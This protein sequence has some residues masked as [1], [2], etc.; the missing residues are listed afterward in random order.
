MTFIASDS[1][2][3]IIPNDVKF[4]VNNDISGRMNIINISNYNKQL[5]NNNKQ[6]NNN[7]KQFS[8]NLKEILLS[9]IKNEK[10]DIE[11]I[12]NK[13]NSKGTDLEKKS[14]YYKLITN[15]NYNNLINPLYFYIRILLELIKK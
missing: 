12:T 1:K 4:I 6:L 11:K 13:G 8:E 2:V 3:K 5:N 9:I 7:N 10:I 15:E 14:K